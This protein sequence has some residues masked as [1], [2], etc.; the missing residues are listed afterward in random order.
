MDGRDDRIIFV[1]QR[2]AGLV[3]GGIWRIQRQF[4]E[5]AFAPEI[6][7]GDLLELDQ[8]CAPGLAVF[9]DAVEMRIVPKARTFESRLIQPMYEYKRK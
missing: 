1:Q 2:H 8:V 7:A 4:G 9:V 3:A 5:K 6:A